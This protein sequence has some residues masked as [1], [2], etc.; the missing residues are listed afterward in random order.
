MQLSPEKSDQIDRF[1]TGKMTAEEAGRFR[2]QMNFDTALAREVD[3]HAAAI[4]LVQA[5]AEQEV[6]EAFARAQAGSQAPPTTPPPRRTW[7]IAAGIGF[8]LLLGLALQTLPVRPANS[9]RI[10]LADINVA[11]RLFLPA[12]PGGIPVAHITYHV[13]ERNF[14]FVSKDNRT[15]RS[16]DKAALHPLYKKL[17]AQQHTP[18]QRIWVSY[19]D[20]ALRSVSY[21]FLRHLGLKPFDPSYSSEVVFAENGYRYEYVPVEVPYDGLATTRFVPGAIAIENEG[22]PHPEML[23]L[24]CKFV[25][26]FPECQSRGCAPIRD[27]LPEGVLR[28]L[29]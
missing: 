10:R 26:F 18:E 8:L 29:I 11:G 6:R 23:R 16:I 28:S 12:D 4:A 3:I 2:V 19:Q 9:Q 5:K 7:R 25:E 20:P 22:S 1:L 27:Y 24:E 13:R 14:Y 15:I 17:T 21:E